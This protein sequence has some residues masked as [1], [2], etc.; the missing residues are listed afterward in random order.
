MYLPPNSR[1]GGQVPYDTRVSRLGADRNLLPDESP[2]RALEGVRLRAREETL[3]AGFP[4]AICQ[5]VGIGSNRQGLTLDDVGR[6]VHETPI[7]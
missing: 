3:L 6:D 2:A 7:K 5:S 4:A 1:P